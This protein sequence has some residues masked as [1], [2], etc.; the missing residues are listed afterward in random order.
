MADQIRPRRWGFTI[1]ELFV[2]LAI[3]GVLV[4]LLFL[5]PVTRGR[6]AS[7]RTQCRN[8]LKQ[9][10]LALHNYHDVYGAFPPAYTV[11]VEG[12]PLHSWRTL[13][14]PYMDQKPLYD[15]IDLSKPWDDPANAEVFATRISVFA[16]PSHS[17]PAERTTYV[18][19]VTPNSLFRQEKSCTIRDITDGTS[20]TL[21][22]IEIDPEHAVPWMSPQDAEEA[23]F[24]G[25][26]TKKQL[27][28]VGGS[29]ALFADGAVRFLS[30][31]LPPETR[32]AIV[33]IDGHETVGEF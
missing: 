26:A 29:H 23:L 31:N 17:V 20:E 10:G 16:C 28:H 27:P 6:E 32:Q 2:V 1:V 12:K 25:L 4:G 13:L 15:R 9:I 14:L 24:H 19:I 11:D 3:I 30:Q 22:V 21:A 18:A 7:R 33:T 8:N 5:P